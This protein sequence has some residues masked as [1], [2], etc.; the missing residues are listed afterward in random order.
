MPYQ[1]R[2]DLPKNVTN[3]LPPHAQDI[4]KEAFNSAYEQ[5]KTSTARKQ[6]GSREDAARRVAWAAVKQKYEKGDDGR[7]H[8]KK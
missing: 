3:V 5:Y 8:P 1:K 2:E 7:W 6:G 4:F